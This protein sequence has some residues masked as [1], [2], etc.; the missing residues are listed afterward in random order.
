MEKKKYFGTI[1]QWTVD[2]KLT[3]INVWKGATSNIPVDFLTENEAKVGIDD[4]KE[5]PSV[6]WKL[7]RKLRCVWETYGWKIMVFPFKKIHREMG[8]ENKWEKCN[9][10]VVEITVSDHATITH[11]C[12]VY[13]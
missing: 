2:G 11:S 1:W 6:Q 7:T 12:R 10:L 4:G 13:D 9:Y 3:P 5:S 8:S